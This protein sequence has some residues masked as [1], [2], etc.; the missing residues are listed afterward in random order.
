MLYLVS[1]EDLDRRFVASVRSQERNASHHFKGL[2]LTYLAERCCAFERTATIDRAM[3]QC[4]TFDEG[5]LS[6]RT[7]DESGQFN[8]ASFHTKRG[9]CLWNLRDAIPA[10]VRADRVRS[11][12]VCSRLLTDKKP[13]VGHFFF[14]FFFPLF[15]IPRQMGTNNA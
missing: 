11:R 7:S 6:L 15:F 8:S 5:S 3:L 1:F 13:P 2:V 10:C 12:Y 4:Y 14:P 9:W